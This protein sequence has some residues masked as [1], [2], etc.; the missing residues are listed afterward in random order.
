MKKPNLFIVG[1]PRNGTSSLHDYLNQHPDIFM[2]PI[3]EPNYFAKDFQAESDQFHQKALYFPFRT[4]KSYLKRYK[5]WSSEKVGGESS[6]SNLYSK[7]AFQEIH[8]F[9]MDSKIIM[10][11][12]EP[13]DFL[14]SYHSTACFS[15]GE[16]IKDLQSALA[17][18]AERK[19]GNYLSKRVITP[20]WLYYSE[21]I[22]YSE[23]LS[24]YL[25]LFDR[26]QIK[27]LIFDDFKADPAGIYKEILKFLEV[28]PNFEPELKIVNPFKQNSKWPRLQ[29]HLIDS[30]YFRK[31]LHLI[32]PDSLYAM[33]A[34][35]YLIK[36]RKS[37]APQQL[38]ASSVKNELKTRFYHEVEQLSDLLNRNLVELWGYSKI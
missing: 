25:S 24:R 4:E 3:K 32:L 23:H 26:R 27:V 1:H 14:S 37:E 30:P 8:R 31:F 19:K 34:N 22:N 15:L 13:I 7:I 29:H 9:N 2:S 21:F 16:N 28:D 12:R 18:E 35:Y 36:A 6:A 5:G 38:I 20:S 17:V 10:S 33:L 11:F